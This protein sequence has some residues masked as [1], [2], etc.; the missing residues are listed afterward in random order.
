LTAVAIFMSSSTSSSFTVTPV[1]SIAA[2]RLVE[3][4]RPHGARPALNL[5]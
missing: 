1:P 2:G 5:G 3:V 4:A